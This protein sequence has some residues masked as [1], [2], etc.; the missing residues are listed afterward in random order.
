MTRT[1]TLI[2]A[3]I[4]VLALVVVLSSGLYSVRETEYVVVTQFGE[5]KRAVTQAG[6]HWKTPFIQDVTR[7]EKR[8]L[9]W[10]GDPNDIFTEDKKNIFID[11]WARWRVVD[12]RQFYVTLNGRLREGQKKLDDIVDGVVR[13][14]ISRYQLYELV[15]TTNR[16]LTYTVETAEFEQRSGQ[17]EVKVGR[18]EIMDE[19]QRIAGEGLK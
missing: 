8:V 1:I 12:P 2:L 9:A 18:E 14:V 10:D 13:D 17:P 3:G 15:R 11:T 5:L 7:I 19:I 6:L 16:E 4:A